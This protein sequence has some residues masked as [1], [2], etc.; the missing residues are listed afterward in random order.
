MFKQILGNFN[1]FQKVLL[2]LWNQLVHLN[3]NTIINNSF[4]Q[5]HCFDYLKQKIF[6]QFI[7][8]L[9]FINL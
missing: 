1:N 7:L 8:N 9:K 5:N 4:K 3:R 2:F 6:A